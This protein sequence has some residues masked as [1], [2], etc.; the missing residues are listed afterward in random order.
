MSELVRITIS[1]E[2]DLLQRFDREVERQGYPTR[3]E[4]LKALMR[5]N[6]VEQEWSGNQEVAGAIAF[7]Y[8]H[9]RK[10]LVIKALDVQHDF[11]SVIV[12]TQHVHLDH[13]NCLEIV[14]VRGRAG[15]I[16][17]LSRALKAIKGIKHNVLVMTSIGKELG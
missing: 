5:K 13:N 12:S 11:G 14:V 16:Q 1:L 9:H 6:L 2:E 4:A 15:R 3:S 7:V 17:D 10:G 8:D